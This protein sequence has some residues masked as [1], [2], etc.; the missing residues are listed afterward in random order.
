MTA[1]IRLCAVC[2]DPVVRFACDLTGG[3][4]MHD[5]PTDDP[6]A[7]ADHAAV[8]ATD[9]PDRT[10]RLYATPDHR[11]WLLSRTYID[12]NGTEWTWDQHPYDLVAG[13]EMTS[14]S[15]PFLHLP[16]LGLALH[17][18]LHSDTTAA[19]AAGELALQDHDAA[20]AGYNPASKEKVS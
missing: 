7:G 17:C 3:D 10:A 1:P 16:L 6:N 2:G 8:P 4:W 15:F 20:E 12:V 19:M 11:V 13:P 14:P 5:I 18:G 9:G